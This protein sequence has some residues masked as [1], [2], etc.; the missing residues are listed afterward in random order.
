MPSPSRAAGIS[1]DVQAVLLFDVSVHEVRVKVVFDSRILSIVGVQGGC[2]FWIG[3][4]TEF[5]GIVDRQVVNIVR[6]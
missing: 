2:P 3:D 5:G 6:D 4:S 1:R